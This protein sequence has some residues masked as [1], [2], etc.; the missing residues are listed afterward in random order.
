MDTLFDETASDASNGGYS[1]AL[2]LK[3]ESAV[4]PGGGGRI[5]GFLSPFSI[6]RVERGG[7]K[8]LGGVRVISPVVASIKR[9][10]FHPE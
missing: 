7:R 9:S 4:L 6:A 10:L 3:L 5:P 2:K 8:R 1:R